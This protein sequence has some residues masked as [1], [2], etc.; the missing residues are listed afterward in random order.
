LSLPAELLEAVSIPD[1]GKITLV[2]GAGCSLEEPTAIPLASQCS[3]EC[4]ARLVASG[5]L[6]AGDCPEPWN[7]SCLADAVFEKTG[8]YQR[9]L[10]EQLSRH[11]RLKNAPPNE[12]HRLAAALL[13][14]G[15]ITSVLTLNFDLAL[16]TAISSMGGADRIAVID[17]P[18]QLG[19]QKAY[20]LY[21]LHGNA[22]AVD[23]ETWVLRTEALTAEWRD[24]WRQ[25]VATKVL[26]SPVVVF[27]GLGSPA[28]VL[29]ETVRL[30]HQAMPTGT[31]AYQVDPGD[32]NSSAFFE[33]LALDASRYVQATWCDFM[34]DL[35]H[36]LVLEHLA[37]LA[38][39][40]GRLT[41][42]DQLPPESLDPLIQR[43]TAMGL[44]RLGQLRANWL[45][46]SND[47]LP[48]EPFTRDLVADLLLAVALI[49]RNSNCS[50]VIFEDGVVELRRDNRILAALI[51]ASGRGVRGRIDMEAQIAK[52]QRR[53]R[54]RPTPPT[55]A[56]V[57]ATRDSSSM[58]VVS[59][60]ADVLRGDQP[61]S[62]VLGTTA[63]P[64]LHV[65]ALRDDSSL[66]ERL[67]S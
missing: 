57:T 60:P 38:A 5:I 32:R 23:P 46:E 20:N 47:Y 67:V 59:P 35:S 15:A 30:I 66:L 64:L 65:S 7:L 39:A 34:V 18:Q 25:V 44:L 42:R 41:Q 9:P 14:E 13:R 26:A 2:V 52:R 40:A 45:L 10:V 55:V 16:S 61:E 28:D 36:R 6:N 58:A 4:H 27:A 1:G 63:L 48:D 22:S 37:R 11:Y 17:G 54:G 8:G 3:E 33:A 50:A 24:H 21:Y 43:I 62:I 29:I 56:V 49:A 51:F 12:G 19:D 53:L 31:Q